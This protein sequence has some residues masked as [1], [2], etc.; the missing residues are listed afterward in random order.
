MQFDYKS[1]SEL[2]NNDILHYLKTHKLNHRIII[3]KDHGIPPLFSYAT[4]RVDIIDIDDKDPIFTKA[5][6]QGYAIRNKPIVSVINPIIVRI[7]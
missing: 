7:N 1:S 4:I 5:S 2:Q 6:Y 3:I